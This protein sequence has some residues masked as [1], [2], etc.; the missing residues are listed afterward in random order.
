MAN[1]KLKNPAGGSLN[2]VSADGASD[3]TV[4][5][6]ATT[7]TA[8]VSGNMPA[9]SAYKSASQ[10]L[11]Y[12]TLTKVTFNTEEFDTNNNFASSTFTPTVAGYYQINVKGWFTGT[13]TRDY[14]LSPRLYKNGSAISASGIS[15]KQLGSAAELSVDLSKLVYMNGTTDYLEVYAYTL[16][17]TA[18]GTVDLAGGIGYTA[19]NGTLVR[20]T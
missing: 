18:S 17:Y 20:A 1:L 12:N 3:L 2:L 16:D 10:T 8:M 6:P 4:T 15:I 11:A 19:F 5:F 7:G 9:F 14:F 13:A